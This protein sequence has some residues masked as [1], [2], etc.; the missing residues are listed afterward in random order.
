MRNLISDIRGIYKVQGVRERSA[1]RIFGPK[2]GVN[3]R[4]GKAV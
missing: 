4:M 1:A 2:T 3:G